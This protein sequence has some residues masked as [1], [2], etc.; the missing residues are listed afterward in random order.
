MARELGKNGI[1][2]IAFAAAAGF[3]IGL[4]AGLVAGE[5]LG[6]VHPERVR[7]AV[8]RFGPRILPA[9]DPQA[10]ERAVLRALRSDPRT[11][12][13]AIGVRAISDGLVELTGTVPATELRRHAAAIAQAAAGD[14][15]VVNRLLVE[16]EDVG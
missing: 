14:D 11:R 3:G 5:W 4:M 12:N 7:R 9:R 2:G 16:G 15:V 6:G 1:A 13:L 10:V 8:R